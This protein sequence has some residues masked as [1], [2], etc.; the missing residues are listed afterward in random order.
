MAERGV[1]GGRMGD[2]GGMKEVRRMQIKESIE[3]RT[4]KRLL[5]RL[6]T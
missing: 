4:E 6:E 2:C 3:R 5:E 1:I